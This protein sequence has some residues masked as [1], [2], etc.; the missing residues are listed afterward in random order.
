MYTGAADYSKIAELK[1]HLAIPVIG[2]G[3]VLTPDDA[4]R[5]F[6]EA[7][8]D[9]VMIGRATMKNPWIFRQIAARRAGTSVPEAP[10][11][12]RRDLMLAHFEAIEASAAE[13]REALHKL[14]TMTG[15]YTHG[16]PRGRDLRVRISSLRTPADFRA[17]VEEFFGTLDLA[18]AS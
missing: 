3:D 7:G 18:L 8:C 14:R 16:L 4:E 6:T 15:W 17:A 11:A 9:A 2:N 10:L 12:E 5:L 1:R 13:P